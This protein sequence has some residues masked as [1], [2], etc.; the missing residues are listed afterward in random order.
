M[1]LFVE[2]NDY[3]HS[4]EDRVIIEIEVK[5]EL[6]V[7]IYEESEVCLNFQKSELLNP[8]FVISLFNKLHVPKISL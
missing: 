6:N 8:N 3:L 4:D 5:S 1:M 7:T 2:L